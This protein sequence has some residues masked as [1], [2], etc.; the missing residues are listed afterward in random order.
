MR[1]RLLSFL[2][3]VAAVAGAGAVA[4]AAAID[5]VESGCRPTWSISSAGGELSVLRGVD[6][7]GP[8]D[9]W[10]VGAT[11]G[12]HGSAGYIEHWDG[13]EWQRSPSPT[14]TGQDLFDV[15]A[16]SAADVWAVGTDIRHWDG[17]A[18]EVVA[19]PPGTLTGIDD[20]SAN[21]V[22]AVGRRVVDGRPRT[23]AMRWNGSAWKVVATPN[24]GSGANELRAV[25]AVSPSDAWAVGHRLLDGRWTTLIQRWDGEAWRIVPSPTVPGTDSF[26]W[27]VHAFGG[28]VWAVGWS[29]DAGSERTLILGWDGEAWRIVPSPNRGPDSSA[30]FD[31]AGATPGDVWAVGGFALQEYP[32]RTLILHWDGRAWKAVTSANPDPQH[33]RLF[34][35]GVSPTG[36]AW[37][38]GDAGL[39]RLILTVCPIDVLS[40]RFA[41]AEMGVARGKSVAWRIPQR[42]T[43]VHS[44]TD[45]SGMG[46]FDSGERRAG[47]SY[48]FT[49]NAA[50]TYPVVDEPTGHRA[51]IQ[52]PMSV[53]PVQDVEDQWT[54]IWA[55]ADVR[56]GFVFDVQATVPGS[57]TWADWRV[58][59]TRLRG[60]FRPRLGP[61]LYRFRARLRN[62][63]NGAASAW[64]LPV[65]IQ[66]S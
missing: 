64:S 17:D 54:V 28:H 38:V 33:G 21:L 19:Q 5:V 52:I 27:G 24:A 30:L 40:S 7:V 1:T 18:W 60:R 62:A 15:A 14:R 2:L 44:V 45:A 63:S 48:A 42:T 20:V 43:G 22:W 50:G 12:P 26:L 8:A 46:L 11:G 57:S 35:A 16:V 61:G 49:F 41:P 58:G 36:Q 53:E 6:V 51:T 13:R 31:V 65:S 3:C 32:Q 9:V 25:S 37:A 56:Q 66:V 34:G 47:E 59:E 4:P 23:L 55:S 29:G 10:A 39:G